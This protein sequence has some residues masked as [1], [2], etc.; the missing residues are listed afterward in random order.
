MVLNAKL[1]IIVSK[2]N[3]LERFAWIKKWGNCEKNLKKLEGNFTTP[4]HG[5]YD[6]DNLRLKSKL[7]HVI[8]CGCELQPFIW[9]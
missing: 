5:F 3:G 1:E 6:Y 4:K 2:I 8:E 9:L 7:S